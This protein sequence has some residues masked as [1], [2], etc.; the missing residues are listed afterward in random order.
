MNY[1]NIKLTRLQEE[2]ISPQGALEP[3]R[4]GGDEMNLAEF[5][6]ALLADRQPAGVDTVEFSDVIKG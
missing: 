6:F 5:P 3:V 1:D 4:I 2:D